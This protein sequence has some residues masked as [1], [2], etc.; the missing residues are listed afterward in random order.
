MTRTDDGAWSIAIRPAFEDDRLID[1][2]VD[3]P[4][5]IAFLDTFADLMT[6]PPADGKYRFS[7]LA[8]TNEA[9][10]RV[11]DGFVPASSSLRWV[12]ASVMVAAEL[13]DHDAYEHSAVMEQLAGGPV[14]FG[15][16]QERERC[17]LVLTTMLDRLDSA[18]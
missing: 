4:S 6:D 10:P 11:E 3:D 13:R 5:A 8:A 16:E 15:C 2:T 18:Q 7:D 17:R 12:A 9:M 14:A 1:V